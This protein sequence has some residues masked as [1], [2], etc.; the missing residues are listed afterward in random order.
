MKQKSVFIIIFLLCHVIKAQ[1]I[2]MFKD[3]I[4]QSKNQIKTL[5]FQDVNLEKNFSDYLKESKMHVSSHSINKFCLEQAKIYSNNVESNVQISNLFPIFERRCSTVITFF[6]RVNKQNVSPEFIT[7]L[8]E[9]NFKY[10]YLEVISNPFLSKLQ[11]VE[12]IENA[13]QSSVFGYIGV[14]MHKSI[15]L[16]QLLILTSLLICAA[17]LIL[18]SI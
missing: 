5:N 4:S 9:S 8:T 10:G 13:Y 2:K 1:D 17:L 12:K 15:F 7:L 6:N 14:Q 11:T 16:E 3:M 18:K